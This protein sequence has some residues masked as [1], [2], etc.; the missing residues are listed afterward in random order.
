MHRPQRGRVPAHQPGRG[1]WSAALVLLGLAGPLAAQAP[2][3][4]DSVTLV[5]GAQYQ[6]HG[7]MS[8]PS[9]L[10]FGTNNRR[11]WNEPLTLPVVDPA[12]RGGGLVPTGVAA[13]GPDSGVLLFSDS[14]GAEWQFRPLIRSEP[15]EIPATVP[16]GVTRDLVLDLVSGKNPAGPLVAIPLAQAAA[17]PVQRGQLV[18]LA[19]GPGLGPFQQAYGGRA[20]YLVGN[21]AR[22]DSV[23]PEEIASGTVIDIRGLMRRL[24]LPVPD[25]IDRQAVLRQRLF[26]AFVGIVNPRW[27]DWRW[28]AARDSLGILWQPLGVFPEMALADYNGGAARALRPTLPDL[29][30][31][32]PRYPARLTGTP[33]QLTV[34]RW[35]IGNLS[36]ATWDSVA[37][38]LQALMTDSVIE[39]AVSRLPPSYPSE[40][41]SQLAA[42]LRARRDGL[43]GAARRLFGQLRVHAELL[44]SAG[45]D[46]VEVDRTSDDTVAIRLGQSEPRIFAGGE[47][48]EVRL[49]LRGGAD[50]VKVTGLENKRPALRIIALGD[51]G[52]NLLEV[53]PGA[54]GGLHLSDP[55]HA[56]RI[57]PSGAVKR[58]RASY[59]DPLGDDLWSER[60]PRESGVSYRPT[61]W[62][63]I[64]SGIGILFG[65][66]VVRTDW[67][68]TARPFKSRMRLRAGYGT[69]AQDG[70]VEFTSVFY[71]ASTPLR[72]SLGLAITGLALVRFYGYGNETA[73]PGSSSYYRST[74]N[75]Y[76]VLPGVS[77]PFRSHALVSAGL[78]FKRVE[79]PLL[80]NQYISVVEP[81]GTPLFGQAGLTGG[82]SWDSRD[83][84]GAPHRGMYFTLNGAWY[85]I[86]QNGSGAFGSIGG[87]VSTYWTPR[88][89]SPLTVAMRVAGK[90]ALGHYPVHEAAYLG[91]GTTVR[92]L[93]EGRYAGDE[94]LYGNLDLRIRLARARAVTRW[95]FGVLLLGDVGRVF[96]EGQTSHVWHPSFG[97]G[98]WMALLDR[99][100]VA[101]IN[102]ASGAGQGTFV[103]FGGGFIF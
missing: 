35:L 94:S 92:G 98:L 21:L 24:M 95:D 12:T 7:A 62:L 14:A 67:N 48:D 23:P 76:L 75:Q 90:A 54:G 93:P 3:G 80:P 8:R 59:P 74:Q 2:V 72:T 61:P 69:E 15:R 26:S 6:V 86:I 60:L 84:K 43:P 78:A 77:L 19:E 85:P 20:G 65:A 57:E 102:V 37:H 97:G 44:G 41:S 56:F 89:E 27:L 70:A 32:G 28:E 1:G 49:F 9:L 81:Y 11:L 45:P 42:S 100:L 31:F 101:N 5:P 13:A 71:Y 33:A 34:S 25:R 103:R 22:A 55:G 99:S 36:W 88:R 47:T 51:S 38:D 53:A 16:K 4:R 40:F 58:D 29:V 79:T 73:A 63:E 66:G 52:G 91:G 87:A 18:V 83:V 82:L 46:L 17:V 64:T 10:L 50:T 30:N 39:L 96:L 68:G